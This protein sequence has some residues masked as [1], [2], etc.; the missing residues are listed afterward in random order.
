MNTT[1]SLCKAM[2]NAN[3]QIDKMAGVENTEAYL[4]SLNKRHTGAYLVRPDGSVEFI[5]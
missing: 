5:K 3:A 1:D 4:E 2:D